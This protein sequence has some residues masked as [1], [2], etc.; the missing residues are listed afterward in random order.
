MAHCLSVSLSVCLSVCKGITTP[1][2]WRNAY[3]HTYKNSYKKFICPCTGAWVD[4]EQPTWR[5]I[6][7]TK[8]LL[9]RHQRRLP[10][11]CRQWNTAHTS[12]HT[13][14]IIYTILFWSTQIYIFVYKTA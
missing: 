4:W 9:W 10:G 8:T 6:T 2:I 13:Y 11:S 5:A 1:P 14:C 12:I 3:I 7:T